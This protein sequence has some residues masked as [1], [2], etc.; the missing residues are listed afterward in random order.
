M[1]LY[2]KSNPDPQTNQGRYSRAITPQ[3]LYPLHVL[4]F[5]DQGASFK[6]EFHLLDE[7]APGLYVKVVNGSVRLFNTLITTTNPADWRRCDPNYMSGGIPEPWAGFRYC[8][9][10]KRVPLGQSSPGVYCMNTAYGET[11][12]L[13][14]ALQYTIWK[15]QQLGADPARIKVLSDWFNS[16][17]P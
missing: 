7:L 15:S 13:E 2:D 6:M 16:A 1:T 9:D 10:Q 17:I 8:L 11:A 14:Q 12:T 4:D 5:V 3:H